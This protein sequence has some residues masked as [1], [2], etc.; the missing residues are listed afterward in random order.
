ML[1]DL[2]PR[3][4]SLDNPRRHV[5]IFT[6]GAWEYH[7]ATA[8]AVLLDSERRLAFKIVVP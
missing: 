2:G 4:Q 5:A 6:D 1:I 8:G 3:L 7:R